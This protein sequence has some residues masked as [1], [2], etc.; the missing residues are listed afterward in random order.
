MRL[1]NLLKDINIDNDYVVVGVSTG[2][3]SMALFHYL[4][5]NT[6]KKIICAHINH[7]VRK[8]SN[9]EEEYLRNYCLEN[10]I[11][12][13]TIKLTNYQIKYLLII[14]HVLNRILSSIRLRM[15]S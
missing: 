1:N 5:N 3:D 9:E 6:S 13:E 4:I 14:Q 12:F 2:C 7:N 8:E 11:I 15:Q 10:N